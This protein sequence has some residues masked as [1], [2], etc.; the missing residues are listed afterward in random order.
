MSFFFSSPLE[1]LAD[2]ESISPFEHTYI[3]DLGTDLSEPVPRSLVRC[4][5]DWGPEQGFQGAA[6]GDQEKLS[7]I[8]AN[9]CHRT[10]G[11]L[12]K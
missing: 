5:E 8:V 4:V 2:Q 6:D 9:S 10:G 3:S 12:A 7:M 11:E 1:N